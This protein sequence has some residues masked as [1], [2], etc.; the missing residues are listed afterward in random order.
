MRA[1][2]RVSTLRRGLP[3]ELQPKTERAVTTSSR[4]ASR[5]SPA[6]TRCSTFVR[7]TT[8]GVMSLGLAACSG[9]GDDDDEDESEAP[10]DADASGLWLGTFT[11][12]SN[13]MPFAVIASPSGAFIGVVI[14][15]TSTSG[16]LMVGTGST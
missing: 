14:G 12:A 15:N 7:L 13:S 10:D 8:F 11:Q 3:E 9:G 5:W 4:L 16:R 1:T 2:A 6:N